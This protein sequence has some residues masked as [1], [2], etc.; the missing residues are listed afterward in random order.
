MSRALAI[1]VAV[2]LGAAALMV[3]MRPATL[4]DLSRAD[5]VRD[6]DPS[7]GGLQ[8]KASPVEVQAAS[9]ARQVVIGSAGVAV[10]PSSP[11]LT[12]RGAVRQ[13]LEDLGTGTSG[14][15]YL[16]AASAAASEYYNP[17]GRVLTPEQVVELEAL[18]K[19]LDLKHQRSMREV[20]SANRDALLRSLDAGRIE[21][22][23]YLMARE[24]AGE[25]ESVR[26]AEENQRRRSALSEGL[27]RRLGVRDRDWF[28]AVVQ[29]TEP[30]QITR[31]SVVYYMKDHEPGAVAARDTVAVL[32]ENVDGAIRDWFVKK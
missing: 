7:V 19:D 12:V 28:F 32:R 20:S 22:V 29:T 13:V 25:E 30:D 24:G 27:N 1:S 10:S 26:V 21:T 5:L 6:G 15:S 16:N 9:D 17:A 3:L 23:E 4:T 8:S 18:I 11:T 2:V 14:P 31:L